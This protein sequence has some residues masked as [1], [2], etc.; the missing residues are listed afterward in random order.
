MTVAGGARDHRLIKAE[1]GTI[2]WSEPLAGG[3]RAVVKLYRH[4]PLHD[5]LR[6]WFVAYRVEREYRMLEILQRQGVA[7]PEPLRWSHGRDRAH[8]RHELLATREIEG[9]VPLADLLARAAPPDLAPLF[10]SARRMHEC[11]VAHGAF[12]PRNVLV[13]RPA[14]QPAEYHLIDF[15][16]GRAFRR[17]IVGSR[18]A[19]YDL[20]DMLRTIARQAPVENAAAWL[21]GYGLAGAQ[22]SALLD[23][24]ATHRIERPWRHFRRMATDACVIRDRLRLAG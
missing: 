21:A 3:G 12:Y 18:P 23:R 9:A 14:G 8:G 1:A 19:D 7:C 2:V 10:A 6:R 4:R 11:G 22:A 20:L 17:S 16:H 24:F 15:A 13:T 5:P